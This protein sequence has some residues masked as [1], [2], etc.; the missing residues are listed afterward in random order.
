MLRRRRARQK[1]IKFLTNFFFPFSKFLVAVLGPV[2]V[3]ELVSVEDAQY[4]RF[5]CYGIKKDI[6]ICLWF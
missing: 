1:R 2:S 6:L 5:A 4:A 3:E